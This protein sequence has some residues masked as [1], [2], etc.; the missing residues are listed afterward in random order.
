MSEF[1]AFGKLPYVFMPACP[2]RESAGENKAPETATDNHK[3]VTVL[4]ITRCNERSPTERVWIWIGG[5]RG[6]E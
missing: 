6:R 3:V 2:V 1:G 4:D 5:Y